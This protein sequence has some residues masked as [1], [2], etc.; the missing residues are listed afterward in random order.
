MAATGRSTIVDSRTQSA[1]SLDLVGVHGSFTPQ[2][3]VVPFL[4]LHSR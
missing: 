1:A 4:T 2:E 3:M